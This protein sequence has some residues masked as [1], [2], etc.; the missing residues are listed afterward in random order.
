MI[1]KYILS[2]SKGLVE[3]T[4]SKIPTVQYIHESVR[5]FLLKEEGLREIWADVGSGFQGRA[6]D[7]LKQC[8]INYISSIDI[9]NPP[10]ELPQDSVADLRKS[11]MVSFPFLR[12]ALD[13]I[14]V[15]CGRGSRDGVRSKIIPRNV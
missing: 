15:P 5:D 7:R 13:N 6:H 14:T 3:I 11:L 4:K 10:P 1:E 9:Q 12:Y 2:S 8:C